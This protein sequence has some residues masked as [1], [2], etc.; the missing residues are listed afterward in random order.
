[1]AIRQILTEPNKTKFIFICNDCTK[2]NESI[3]SKC[4][5]IKFPKISY[6]NIFKKIKFICE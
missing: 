4:M 5:I 6:K 3:Q 1:M 2:I